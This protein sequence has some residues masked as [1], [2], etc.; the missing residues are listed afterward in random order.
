MNDQL[1]M[2]NYLLILKSTMEVYVHGTLESSNEEIRELLKEGLWKDLILLFSCYLMKDNMHYSLSIVKGELLSC[3]CYDN[4]RALK[5]Q[6]HL[7]S[8]NFCKFPHKS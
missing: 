6:I 1:L 5:V 7:L 4:A 8:P 2:D 3:N